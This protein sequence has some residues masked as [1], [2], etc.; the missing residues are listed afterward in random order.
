V[1]REPIPVLPT[2]H[3]NMGGVPTNYRGEVLT[4]KDGNKES[5]V[6]GLMAI[7]EAACVS[8]HGANRLGCNSL[9]DIIVF[10]RAAA[11]HC[12]ET[13]RPGAAVRQ[14]NNGATDKALSRFDARRNA[15]GS[16]PTA[17]MRLRMQ[18]IMQ[19]NCAVFRT[20][21][22]LAE[23]QRLIREVWAARNDVR[24]SDHSLIWNSDLVET[25]EFDN[26]LAQAVVTLDCAANRTESRGAHAREDH[27]D[28]DD[29][30]WLKHSRIWLDS[31]TGKT[32]FDYR[33]VHLSPLSNDVQSFPPT[34]R[35][36]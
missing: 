3:Y 7:G 16:V 33:P 21:D 19:S 26:L 31:E 4:S 14:L 18:K 6:P 32:R 5:V 23:G 17:E 30:N 27:P 24:T 34:K 35:V 36:Y 1:T 9:L 10:G 15:K 25:L 22:I 29:A 13:I 28:R 8:V 11:A 12:A 2:V 20:G